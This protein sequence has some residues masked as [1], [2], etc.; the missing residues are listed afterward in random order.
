MSTNDS[1]G[2]HGKQ[3]EDRINFSKVIAVGVVSLVIF[4]LATWWA[5]AILHGER[6][7]MKNRGEGRMTAEIGKA[8]IGIVDQV[9]FNDDKRLDRWR[10]GRAEWLHGYG[11][12]DR[13]HNLIHI[14]IERAIDEVI[15]GSV[16]PPVSPAPAS[17]PASPPAHPGHTGGAP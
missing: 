4:A 7:E 3:A 5:I 13:E 16:P 6:A 15:A 2:S 14:P 17:V 9:P 12:V 8:E 1:P 10:R 11:W